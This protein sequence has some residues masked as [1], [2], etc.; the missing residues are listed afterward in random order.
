MAETALQ[1]DPRDN[2]LVALQPLAAGTEV[3]FGSSTCPVT[4]DISPKHKMAL[5][6]L[7]PGDLIRMYGMVVGEVTQAIP[8]GGL[9]STR[10][11]RHRAEAYS[12]TRHPV[13]FSLPD[14]TAWAQRTF[15]GYHRADGQVGTRNYWLVLPLVFCEN[16]NVE[17]MKEALDEELGYGSEANSY[18]QHVRRLL[19]QKRASDSVAEAAAQRASSAARAFPNVDG[20][21]FLTHQGGCGGT[22]QDAQALCGLLA[23]Y[24][25][26]P[27]VAG[28]TVL[29]LGCQ[30]AEARMLMDELRARDPQMT[31]P[32]LVFDQQKSGRDSTLMSSALDATF[33]ALEQANTAT[34]APAPLSALTVG[35]KCGGSDGFSGIS[36][37]PA[38]GYLSDLLVQLGTKTLLSEFPELH[39]VEQELI[40][41]CAT[42]QVAQRFYDLMHSYSA[43]A[44]AVHS[45]FD[46]NPSPGNI[47][48]G[49]ITDAIKSAGAARKGGVSTIRDVLDF[50]QYATTP[51]LSLLCTPGNDVECVTAQSGAGANLV[52]F[53]TGLGTP[54]GNPVA[55]VVKIS[56]SSQLAH[57]MADIIDFD[58]GGIITGETTIAE[59]AAQLLEF[60][61]E[62]ANGERLTRAEQLSQ[63]DFIPWKRGVSL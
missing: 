21:R 54:T 1:L 39:G 19:A 56:T 50:P 22:R 41:R 4:Q 44:K 45:G 52:L 6:D 14:P 8:R 46:M 36:A 25:H 17:R 47:Q 2:V 43:R 59:C 32:V 49:L 62:V 60:S 11:V 53:T 34:R 23:G 3:R 55:P 51:G 24:I 38:L 5:V 29:S 57:R 31:K 20:I 28:A 7:E 33:S 58:A 63:Y 13:S 27:N 26:H 15:M 12:A 18:R 48:D 61:I 35:L 9:V 10:N 37:N 30:N 42:D 16:R 40:N